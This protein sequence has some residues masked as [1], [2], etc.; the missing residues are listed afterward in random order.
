MERK[1]ELT[2]KNKNFFSKREELSERMNSL[3]KEV[4]R[5]NS[6]K[7]RL[8]ENISTQINYMWEEYTSELVESKDYLCIYAYAGSSSLP[9]GFL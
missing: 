8:E 6:Q 9:V 4:Y 7:E 2:A 3:D 1:E 5:L